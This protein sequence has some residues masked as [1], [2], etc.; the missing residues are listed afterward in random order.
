[1]LLHVIQFYGFISLLAEEGKK[2]LIMN[3]E[4]IKIKNLEIAKSKGFGSSLNEVSFPEKIALIHS[5][6][7]EAYQAC[8]VSNISE[9]HGLK[10]ELADVLLR[11]LHLSAFLDIN[12][13]SI[14]PNI[15][16]KNLGI[17]ISLLSLHNIIS[18][19]YENYRR[20]QIEAT[21][22]KLVEAVEFLLGIAE[23]EN[24]DLKA[25]A[26][27]KMERNKNRIWDKNSLNE[28]IK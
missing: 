20:K 2:D 23:K 28:N 11:I 10:E 16:I 26:E 18:E 15:K 22:N 7:S 12:V 14:N 19:S 17:E 3:L 8:L 27:N 13:S 21:K 4:D 25:E 1:M 24:F 6:I 5:E 9:A